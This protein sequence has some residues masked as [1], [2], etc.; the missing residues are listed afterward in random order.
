MATTKFNEFN[1]KEQKDCGALQGISSSGADCH[2]QL[3]D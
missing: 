2:Y 3:S 1:M